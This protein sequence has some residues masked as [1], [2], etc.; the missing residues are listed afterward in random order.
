M[1]LSASAQVVSPSVVREGTG[2]RR[3][4][5]DAMELNAWST[6][7]LKNISDWVG[8]K[9]PVSSDLSGKVVGKFGR[10]G[11]ELKQFGL[12]NSIDCRNENELLIGELSN[13]RVQKVALKAGS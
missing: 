13:W 1:A 12:V 9:A 2:E 8:G 11:K 5:L 6:D 4:T 3:K 7:A 10:A